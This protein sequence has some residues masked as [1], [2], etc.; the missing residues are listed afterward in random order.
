MIESLK[1]VYLISLVVRIEILPTELA[2]A[3]V[4]AYH[5][6]HLHLITQA[7]KSP[8]QETMEKLKYDTIHKNP[9]EYYSVQA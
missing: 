8:G 9:I 6:M 4:Q 3:V 1:S 7:Q 5:G 2:R